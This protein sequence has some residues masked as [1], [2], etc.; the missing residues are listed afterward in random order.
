MSSERKLA[1]LLFERIDELEAE[2]KQLKMRGRVL[3]TLRPEE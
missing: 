1:R 2:R 3:E